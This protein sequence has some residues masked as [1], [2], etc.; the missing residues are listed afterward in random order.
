VK[1][2]ALM[3]LFMLTAWSVTSGVSAADN[4]S[5]SR[6]VDETTFKTL[7]M[8]GDGYISRQEVRRETNLERRFDQLDTDRDGRLSREELRGMFKVESPGDTTNRTRS[9]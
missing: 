2:K 7:D 8:D 5:R 6:P 9:K 3:A 4:P 1:H